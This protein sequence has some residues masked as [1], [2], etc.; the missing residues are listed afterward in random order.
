MASLRD[1]RRRITSVKSTGKITK[2]M[3]MVSAAKLRRN[4][5][6]I[7]CVAALR[8]RHGRDDARPGHLRGGDGQLPA[9]AGPRRRGHRGAARHDRRPRPGRRLQR[10]RAA[11]RPCKTR[12]EL[13]AQGRQVQVLAVGRKG[14]G[15]LKFRGIEP[16]QTWA[17]LSDSPRYTDAQAMA[18]R[19]IDSYVAREVDRVQLIYNHFKSPLEQRLMDVTILPIPTEEVT[20]RGRA[21]ARHLPVRTGPGQHLRGAAAGVRGDR[22]LSAPCWSRAPASRARA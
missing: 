20:R 22:H 17:G 13:E 18:K 10:Q 1:I 7:E 5:Q 9:P 6:R 3:E 4:Q 14:I 16:Q 15:S 21:A 2:A 12:R 8:H 19:V 11:R